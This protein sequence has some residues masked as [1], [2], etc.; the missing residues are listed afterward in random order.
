MSTTATKATIASLSRDITNEPE[1]Y[2]YLEGL[3]WKG[4]PVCAHCDSTDVYL[5]VPKNGTS[6]KTRTGNMSER[7][8]WRC[9]GCK[10]QF[11]VLT[12]TIMHG[13]KIPVRIWVLVYFEFMAAKNG[14]SAREIERK[15]GVCPRT[16]WHMM[17][18][19][20]EAMRWDYIPRLKNTT[21]LA[22][23]TYIGGSPKNRHAGD[24]KTVHGRGTE[25][26]P[27]VTMMDNETGE[28][29]SHVVERV[30]GHTL[31]QILMGNVDPEG[32]V[33]VTDEWRSYKP[34]G[35]FFAKHETVN[36]SEGEY[37]RDAY[38]TNRV[39]GFFSQLK[40]S[41]DGTHHHVTTK[42]LAR[43]V[44]EFDYRFTTCKNMDI[45][46][47]ERLL[48]RVGNRS[49]TYNELRGYAS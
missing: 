49:L 45:V 15:Y 46:R 3:R 37:V 13:T 21:V 16:A 47:M 23:E 34:V 25:K 35:S 36:H 10:K 40:R 12:G 27:V 8:V 17:H 5:I 31:G 42:H 44:A 29:R 19:I 41:I 30:D 48:T 4:T 43:Y 38:T 14:I 6:R 1:A 33:L 28:V 22:D 2:A 18:R 7:R 11:S 32:S 39:E 20:R 26:T 9:R 24:R